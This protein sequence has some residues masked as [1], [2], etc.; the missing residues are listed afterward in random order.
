MNIPTADKKSGNDVPATLGVPQGAVLGFLMFLLYI[1]DISKNISSPIRLFADKWDLN[2][3]LNELMLEGATGIQN[4]GI[5]NESAQGTSVHKRKL[6]WV[7][8]RMLS[9]RALNTFST[10][11]SC[12]Y[13]LVSYTVIRDA[14]EKDRREE[15]PPE[16]CEGQIGSR[17]TDVSKE[18]KAEQ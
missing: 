9:A 2:D 7:P 1:N 10:N 14:K 17:N 3:C 12:P 16:I 15:D 13:H 5:T 8:N 18:N 4:R 6:R 11:T